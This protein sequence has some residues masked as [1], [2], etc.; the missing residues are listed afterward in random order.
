MATIDAEAR[1]GSNGG[2]ASSHWL[3]TLLANTL[4]MGQDVNPLSSSNVLWSGTE[5]LDTSD[6]PSARRVPDWMEPTII[7][8]GGLRW[9]ADGFLDGSKP[10]EPAAVAK[11]L[12]L[13][14]EILGAES[15]VPS[16]VPT[17]RGGVQAEW[18]EN[19]VYLEIE[20]DP[21]GSI[22]YYF[23]DAGEEVEGSISGDSAELAKY[24]ERLL[25]RSP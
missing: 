14:A 17:W 12:R 16:I 13:L 7:A 1:P 3:A 19:G 4:A 18:H 25:L 21:D 5:T 11:L 22:E 24:A 6:A 20:A 23:A 10:T 15:P 9:R 8:C 2:N